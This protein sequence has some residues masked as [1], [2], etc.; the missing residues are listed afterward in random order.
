MLKQL[1][2]TFSPKSWR[3]AKENASLR[4]SQEL[5]RK[6]EY[7]NALKYRSTMFNFDLL[8]Q[9]QYELFGLQFIEKEI[10]K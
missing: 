6:A 9:Q 3:I 8:N 2:M 4:H 10:K 7:E 1:F 5:V